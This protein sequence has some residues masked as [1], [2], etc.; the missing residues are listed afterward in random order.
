MRSR[1]RESSR[2][3]RPNEPLTDRAS[4][5]FPPLGTAAIFLSG[6]VD[7]PTGSHAAGFNAVAGA[8]M[9]APESGL[10]VPPDNVPAVVYLQLG[11]P[12]PQGVAH[13]GILIAHTATGGQAP[14]GSR[15]CAADLARSPYGSE[16]T[17]VSSKACFAVRAARCARLRRTNPESQ[18]HSASIVSSAKPVRG[19]HPVAIPHPTVPRWHSACSARCGDLR[20]GH[21]LRPDSGRGLQAAAVGSGRPSGLPVPAVVAWAVGLRAS[22][23][24]GESRTCRSRCERVLT[25]AAADAL[26]WG[27]LA[28]ARRAEEAGMTRV[29]RNWSVH[30]R[31]RPGLGGDGAWGR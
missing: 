12:G 15:P 30:E 23:R 3:H 27:A 2:H 24:Q 1:G 16:F 11:G 28:P 20:T 10:P 25:G 5:D 21:G 4:Q 8:L 14:G 9:R 29:H 13:L 19:K 17:R 18:Q 7:H 31:Y 22:K 6:I 26:A